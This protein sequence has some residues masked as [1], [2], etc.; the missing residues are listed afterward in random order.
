MEGVDYGEGSKSV[1]PK[2]R[3]TLLPNRTIQRGH[4]TAA[5]QD[6]D[7]GRTRYA[8]SDNNQSV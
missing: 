6:P 8:V 4:R 3:Q 1:G 2:F 5:K 7:F